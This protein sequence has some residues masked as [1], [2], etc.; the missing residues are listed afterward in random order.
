M[1]QTT[2]IVKLDLGQVFFLRIKAKP[3]FGRLVGKKVS[4][5]YH[6]RMINTPNLD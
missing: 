3:L 6:F 5:R 2:M 1:S 4:I